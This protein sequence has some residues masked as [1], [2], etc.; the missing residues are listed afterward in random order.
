MKSSGRDTF[1]AHFDPNTYYRLH[2]GNSQTNSVQGTHSKAEQLEHRYGRAKSHDSE[3]KRQ[4][5]VVC[6]P[7]GNG[8]R[9]QQHARISCEQQTE[10]SCSQDEEEQ[11]CAKQSFWDTVLSE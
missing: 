3:M 6:E 1:P 5:S 9:T 8:G 11:C 10:Q 2:P 4:E 7:G